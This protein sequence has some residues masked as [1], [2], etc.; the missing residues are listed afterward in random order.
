M[1]KFNVT[2]PAWQGN[3]E[4]VF[5]SY[6]LLIK[7]DTSQTNMGADI[8]K[9]LKL[10]VPVNVDD[11]SIAFT[12]TQATVVETDFEATF[13]MFWHDYPNK[14][15]RH[16]AEAY[17]PKMSK[18]EQVQACMTIGFYRKYLERNSWC[19]PKI[20]DNWL[21]KKEFLNDWNKM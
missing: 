14:R 20:A 6:G 17:W 16:L 12:G 8:T 18:T 1:R 5:N 4:I 21:K 13:E 19:N 7:I 10:R 2:S 11:I 3:A 9:S 15:N